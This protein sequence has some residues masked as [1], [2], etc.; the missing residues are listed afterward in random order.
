M[1]QLKLIY[2]IFDNLLLNYKQVKLAEFTVG[3]SLHSLLSILDVLT[4]HTAPYKTV[5]SRAMKPSTVIRLILSFNKYVLA[6]KL[7]KTLR[8]YSIE[9][10]LLNGQI[11]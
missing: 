2:K 5:Y 4:G 8:M 10:L 7:L 11:V 3:E 6:N 9:S 1:Q